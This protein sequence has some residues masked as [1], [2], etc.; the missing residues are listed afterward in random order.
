[1][2]SLTKPLTLSVDG[3]ETRF[4]L[5]LMDAFSGACLLKL[6]TEKCLPH[7]AS[8]D[9]SDPETL[10]PEIIRVLPSFLSSLSETELR[11]VMQKCLNHVEQE[12]PA[13]YQPVMVRSSFGIRELEHDT[14][15]CLKLCWEEILFNLEGFFSGSV[16]PSQPETPALSRQDA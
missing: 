4:R 5:S 14:V 1:M 2:R 9:F 15:T 8:L 11:D 16:L 10:G 7:F 12:L 3:A 13:G 6:I